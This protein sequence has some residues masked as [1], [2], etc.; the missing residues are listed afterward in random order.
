[1]STPRIMVTID[2]LVLRGFPPEQQRSVATG[3]Q[4]E[5]ER[6]LVGSRNVSGFGDSRSIARLS[7][8]N[9]EVAADSSPKRIG[10]LAA[11]R[12]AHMVRS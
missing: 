9:L 11:R 2:A 10:S 5:L 12:V 6:L 4:V 1:M 7:A 8:A 3:F